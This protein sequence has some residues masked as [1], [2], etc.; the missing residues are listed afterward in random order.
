M[1]HIHGT[2]FKIVSIDGEDPPEILQGWKDT[3]EIE[4][5]QTVKLAVKF[6][7]KGIYMYHCHLLEH[8]DNG[9][10][11]QVEVN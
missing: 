4:P 1:A 9:M 7:N 2:Q 8:E 6:N 11:G 3:V 10:M 5:G